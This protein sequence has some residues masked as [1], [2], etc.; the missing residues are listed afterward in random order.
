MMTGLIRRSGRYSTRRV[1]P[2]DLK[3]AYGGKREIVKALGTADPAEAKRLHALMWASLDHEFAE[4]RAQLNADAAPASPAPKGPTAIDV[5]AY[6]AIVLNAYRRKREQYAAD[7]KL[8]LFK[9]EAD[10]QLEVCN[11]VLEGGEDFGMTLA[12]AEGMRIGINAALTGEGAAAL[13]SL[14]PTQSFAPAP[15]IDQQTPPLYLNDVISKWQA[16][17]KPKPRTVRDL[18]R[19]IKRLEAQIGKLPI[20]SITKQHMIAF[21]DALLESGTSAANINVI[22]P[23]LGTLF[24]YACDNGIISANPAKGV[25]VLNKQKAKDKRRSFSAEEL[26]ALFAGPVHTQALR[27]AAGGGSAAYWLPLLALYTGARQTELGQL[28]PDDVYEETYMDASGNKLSAWVVRF[29]DNPERG[30]FVKTEGSERRIPIHRDLITLGFLEVA[31]EAK[32]SNRARIFNDIKPNAEGELMGNWSKW[33]SRYL[34][35]TCGVTDRKVVFHSFRHSFKDYCRAL[36]IDSAVNNALTG[37]ESGDVADDYGS[38]DYPL[39]PLVEA[40]NKFTIPEFR[41]PPQP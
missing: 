2:L 24:N 25:K 40:I 32:R 12:A 41:L 13:G 16:E 11:S 1:I 8:D 23:F 27:P 35:G 31:A 18:T 19:S 6:A 4:R 20:Q 3:A 30:Q 28:H 15:P 10:D 39:A 26:S 22:I 38:T 21:K 14:Q 9:T 7:N 17:R 34:R 5:D 33:F 36:N 37:H 29:V